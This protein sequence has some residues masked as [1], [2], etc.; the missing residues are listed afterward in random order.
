[1]AA[2]VQTVGS[3]IAVFNDKHLTIQMK[4]K[5][6]E[7]WSNN[8]AEQFAIA[9]ALEKKKD[10]YHLKGNQWSLAIHTDSRI[11]LDA[12]AIPVTIKT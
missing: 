2:K 5:I 4:I 6:A 8:Q 10:F 7:W 3:G 1:M 12:I 11:T 9:K